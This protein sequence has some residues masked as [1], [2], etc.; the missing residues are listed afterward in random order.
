VPK[1]ERPKSLTSL[2]V[3]NQTFSDIHLRT[4]T[5]SAFPRQ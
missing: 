1:A 5:P 3:T 2:P 4:K